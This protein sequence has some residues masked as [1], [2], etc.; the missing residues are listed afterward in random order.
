MSWN[1]LKDAT[2]VKFRHDGRAVTLTPLFTGWWMW[3]VV[4]DGRKCGGVAPSVREA[5]RDAMLA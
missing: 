4:I 2:L 1:A 3:T 5:T